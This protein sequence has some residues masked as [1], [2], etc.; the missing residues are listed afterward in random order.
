MDENNLNIDEF[1]NKINLKS[2]G[3]PTEKNDIMV[4]GVGG[5]GGN[6]VNHMYH[7]GAKEVT[8][9]VCNTDAKAVEK[10]DV[11][12]KLVIGDGRGAG[13]DPKKG[14]KAA[15]DDI[16]KIRAVFNDH[17]RM[18]FITAGMG[19]GTGTGAGPVVAR[20]AHE[21][22]LLTIG[23]VTI[24][25]LFEGKTK[26]TKALE[27]AE[28][29][30]KY[31]DA[32]LIINNERLTE[33][34]PDLNFL[35]A[36][37]KA[38]DTLSTAARSISEI[39][40]T[41]GYINVDFEDVDRTLRGGGTAII[42]TGYG[43]GDHRVTRAIDDALNSPLLRNSDIYGARSLLINLYMSDEGDSSMSMAEV[44]ELHNFVQGINHEVDIIWGV[45]IDKSLG[46]KVKIT[47]LAAGF[48]VTITEEEQPAAAM[49]GKS[50]KATDVIRTDSNKGNKIA[51]R[52]KKEYGDGL[53][54]NYIVLTPEQMNDDTVIEILEQPTT[55]R[56]RKTVDNLRKGVAPETL[57]PTI[58]L[59]PKK[60]NDTPN[61]IKF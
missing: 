12:N 23:I 37:G 33:I 53:N 43:E 42:S 9:V 18:V 29:M 6:A 1:A 36:F 21:R 31:V 52:I 24:P 15:E 55:S 38:D 30:S 48:D 34:Y 61:Q 3:Q 27:G 39:I 10:S 2:T 14:E 59:S 4:I 19:G 51:G 26:I 28:E 58:D 7:Q 16:E 32:L 11:P 57:R 22:G 20:V 56:D 5:G 13:N 44:Q 8:F 25:F 49:R 17:V 40:T 41:T 45:T 35:N 60:D 54:A 47:I 50:V 46:E